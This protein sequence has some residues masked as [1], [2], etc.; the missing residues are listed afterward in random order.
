VFKLTM[1]NSARYA[2]A[3]E[4]KRESDALELGT[5]PSGRGRTQFFFI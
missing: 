4:C 3:P 2:G 1:T 5:H